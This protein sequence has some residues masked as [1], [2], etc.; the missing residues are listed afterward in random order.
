MPP[1][2][3]PTTWLVVPRASK[4]DEEQVLT[5]FALESDAPLPTATKRASDASGSGA[6]RSSTSKDAPPVDWLAVKELVC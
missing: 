5:R 1:A 2:I 4:A 6:E 3:V